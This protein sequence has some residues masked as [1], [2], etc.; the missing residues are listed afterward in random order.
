MRNRHLSLERIQGG[1][2]NKDPFVAHKDEQRSSKAL[3]WKWIQSG[4]LNL[5]A[6]I[7]CQYLD[8]FQKYQ[9]L[10]LC[11]GLPLKEKDR[12]RF[13]V[14]VNQKVYLY[15]VVT[16]HQTNWQLIFPMLGESNL[17]TET[18]AFYLP[19]QEWLLL[20]DAHQSIEDFSVIVSKTPL[21][22]LEAS[23]EMSYKAKLPE[24]LRA[25]MVPIVDSKQDI[26][27][28]LS[29]KPTVSPHKV[30]TGHK[31]LTLHFQIFR[32]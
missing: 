30:A 14:E 18:D 10:E 5:K 8:H 23:R 11:D 31:T 16:D 21:P 2:T 25:Y 24:D 17:I 22:L 15:L 19:H 32:Q 28:R 7:E 9:L 6:R 12:V 1:R 20:D 26:L 4:D 27:S 3:T 13:E 29:N